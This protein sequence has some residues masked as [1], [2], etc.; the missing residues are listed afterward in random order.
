MISAKPQ[1]P[2]MPQKS[3]FRSGEYGGVQQHSRLIETSKRSQSRS[4]VLR[5]CTA[6]TPRSARGAIVHCVQDASASRQPHIIPRWRPCCCCG[7]RSSHLTLPCWPGDVA[8][9]RSLAEKCRAR[10]TTSSHRGTPRCRLPRSGR[11]EGREGREETGNET[12]NEWVDRCMYYTEFQ[13]EHPTLRLD[14][15]LS[16]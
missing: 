3:Q 4:H 7:P 10:G 8:A 12:T 11:K 9:V 16:R 15:S 2:R 1:K 5:K 6:C 14:S 13:A